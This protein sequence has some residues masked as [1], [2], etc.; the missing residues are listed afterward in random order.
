MLGF[1]IIDDLDEIP[2]E[3]RGLH[4][5]NVVNLPRLG[6]VQLEL[7]PSARDP[8]T[9]GLVAALA[10]AVAAYGASRSISQPLEDDGSRR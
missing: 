7:P 8:A 3:L 1:R 2:R 9:P 10:E 4:P 6:G 5:R